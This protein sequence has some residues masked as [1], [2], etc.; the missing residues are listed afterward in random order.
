MLC[1][2]LSASEKAKDAPPPMPRAPTPATVFQD[3]NKTASPVNG[4]PGPVTAPSSEHGAKPWLKRRLVG[5][6]RSNTI[7]GDE[8]EGITAARR[9]DEDGIP[10]I[11]Q[12][13]EVPDP[14][15]AESDADDSDVDRGSGKGGRRLAMRKSFQSLSPVCLTIVNLGEAL[16]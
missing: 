7:T 6:S 1:H 13:I 9:D 8:L 10:W 5:N 4:L 2:S 15:R 12:G 14:V 3:R 11:F 16:T